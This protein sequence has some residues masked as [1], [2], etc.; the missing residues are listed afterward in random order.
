MAGLLDI[1]AGASSHVHPQMRLAREAMPVFMRWFAAEVAR[2]SPVGHLASAIV[3]LG[4][5]MAATM[6]GSL[7]ASPADKAK[8]LAAMADRFAAAMKAESGRIEA[9]PPGSEA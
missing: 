4:A 7:A 8:I 9:A 3:S 2:G 6:T 1:E 5:S